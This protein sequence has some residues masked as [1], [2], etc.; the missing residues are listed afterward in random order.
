PVSLRASKLKSPLTWTVLNTPDRELG[1]TRKLLTSLPVRALPLSVS[2]THWPFGERPAVG[3][4][5]PRLGSQYPVGTV[6]CA[7]VRPE[8]GSIAVRRADRAT[9]VTVL[10]PD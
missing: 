1:P 7:I 4:G 10:Y 9:G 6:V 5:V 2:A 3:P 8:P